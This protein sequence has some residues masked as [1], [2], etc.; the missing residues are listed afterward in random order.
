VTEDDLLAFIASA[1][2]SVWAVELL[3][4]LKREPDRA[5]GP[6]SLVRELR[7]S[8]I[9]INEA[10]ERLRTAGLIIRESVGLY[11]YGAASPQLNCMA[12]QLEEVYA[13]KPT[14]VIKAIA[15]ARGE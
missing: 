5:W 13:T 8:P 1:I 11:R 12:S 3:L 7:S 4:L 14:T 2:G 9:V 6:E 10:L 15:A